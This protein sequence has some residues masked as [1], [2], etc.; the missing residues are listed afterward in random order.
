MIL[1]V[2]VLD[3]MASEIPA[4]HRLLKCWATQ[5]QSTRALSITPTTTLSIFHPRPHLP[6]FPLFLPFT[7]VFPHAAVLFSAARPTHRCR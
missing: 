2:P 3:F 4:A 1:L 6:P 7:F 5:I